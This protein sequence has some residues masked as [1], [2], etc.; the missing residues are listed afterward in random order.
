MVLDETICTIIK[1]KGN[2]GRRKKN[3]RVVINVEEQ[4]VYLE[5]ELHD[6]K[7]ECTVLINAVPLEFIELNTPSEMEGL[8]SMKWIS[9]ALEN[10]IVLTCKNLGDIASLLISYGLCFS[11]DDI[12]DLLSMIKCAFCE[13][14]FIERSE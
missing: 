13:N 12:V 8:F 2:N 1:M 5:E 11:Q 7:T 14:G 9:N 3:T 4:Q 6:G 10:P